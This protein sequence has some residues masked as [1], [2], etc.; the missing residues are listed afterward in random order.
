MAVSTVGIAVIWGISNTGM[1]KNGSAITNASLIRYASQSLTRTTGSMEHVDAFGEVRGFTTYNQ[2][3]QIQIE[4]YP[5]GTS[6]ANARTL[7]GDMPQPGDRVTLAD[8]VDSTSNNPVLGDW[9]CTASDLRQSNSDKAVI[10]LTL[11]R[12]AGI[13]SYTPVS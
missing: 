9:I 3:S 8:T 2:S 12:F 6:V 7:R 1:D 11:Q 4:C 5:S 10:S 13:T